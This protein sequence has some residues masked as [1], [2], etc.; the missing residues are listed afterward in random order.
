MEVVLNPLWGFM[1]EVTKVFIGRVKYVCMIVQRRISEE[2]YDGRLVG[3]L[4]DFVQKC[5]RM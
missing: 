1:N 3:I 2:V 5:L 4:Y